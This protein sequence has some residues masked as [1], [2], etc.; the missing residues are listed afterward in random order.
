MGE[1][2][3][4]KESNGR[5]EEKIE[6]WGLQTSVLAYRIKRNTEIFYTNTKVDLWPLALGIFLLLDLPSKF[7]LRKKEWMKDTNTI[8]FLLDY[9]RF[10][11][12]GI[13]QIHKTL[14]IFSRDDPKRMRNLF[15]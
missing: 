9:S 1:S 13:I 7:I 6:L 10:E 3:S 4:M 12:S 2:L 11:P 15:S 5:K 8:L 14:T